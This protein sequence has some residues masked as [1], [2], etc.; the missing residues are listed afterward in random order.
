MI[1]YWI[2]IEIMECDM[3]HWSVAPGSNCFVLSTGREFGSWFREMSL[4]CIDPLKHNVMMSICIILWNKKCINTTFENKKNTIY[5]NTHKVTRHKLMNEVI[6]EILTILCW[7]ENW[8][9]SKGCN[10]VPTT[11][12]LIHP[13]IHMLLDALVNTEAHDLQ[14][15]SSTKLDL[16]LWIYIHMNVLLWHITLFY[17]SYDQCSDPFTLV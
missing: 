14:V 12:S 11:C 15:Y 6:S 13:N 7:L 1:E 8:Y 17:L 2:L 9:F 4:Q 10:F 5:L 16:T 3:I